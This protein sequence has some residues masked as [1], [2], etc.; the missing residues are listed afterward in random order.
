MIKH[1]FKNSTKVQTYVKRQ[2]R[3]CSPKAGMKSPATQDTAANISKVFWIIME[4]GLPNEQTAPARTRT[5]SE[6]NK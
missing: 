5:P 2:A 3:L 6:K 1:V 4:E